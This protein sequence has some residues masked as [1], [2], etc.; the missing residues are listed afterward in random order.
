MV[1]KPRN[2]IVQWEAPPI[3]VKKEFKYL[4][5][6]RANPAEYVARYG[7]SLKTSSELPD[8]VLDIKPPSG[9]VLA[10]DHKPSSVPELEGDLHALNLI[11][12]DKEGLSEYRSQLLRASNY[13]PGQN[14]NV[15]GGAGKS[16]SYQTPHLIPQQQ[17]QQQQQARANYTSPNVYNPDCSEYNRPGGCSG[18]TNVA[19]SSSNIQLHH[20]GNSTTIASSTW[21][22]SNAV[23]IDNTNEDLLRKIFDLIDVDENGRIKYDEAHRILCIINEKF[24]R[25]N[26]DDTA[27][28]F[29]QMFDRNRDGTVDFDE[30]KQTLRIIINS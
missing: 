11:D 16:Y 27:R 26:T 13:I 21:V 4:G 14:N 28:R 29:L 19:Y 25:N 2:V 1:V 7:P 6:I 8:F 23:K 3:Q 12:L 5:I 20:Q 10:A 22:N 24:N 18:S 30:F 17:Q 15:Y 9:V